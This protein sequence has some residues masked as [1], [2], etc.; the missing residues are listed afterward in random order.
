MMRTGWRRLMIGVADIQV[1]LV[2]QIED[3]RGIEPTLCAVDDV[4]VQGRGWETRD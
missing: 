1:Q 4:F 2:Y 3:A